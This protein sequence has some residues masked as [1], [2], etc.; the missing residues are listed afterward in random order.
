MGSARGG[1]VVP[2]AR[3][4]EPQCSDT[5]HALASTQLPHS[6]PRATANHLVKPRSKG[7]GT[8]PTSRQRD[9]HVAIY[10]GEEAHG[11]NT[12]R[13]ALSQGPL[14]PLLLSRATSGLKARATPMGSRRTVSLTSR[15]CDPP[16]PWKGLS[17]SVLESFRVVLKGCPDMP[18]GLSPAFP[19]A[20]GYVCPTTGGRGQQPAEPRRAGR[21]HFP[22][23]R[24]CRQVYARLR[25]V[26]SSQ[27]YLTWPHL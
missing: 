5:C 26:P 3:E 19:P 24:C 8:D 10:W 13:A 21:R 15:C 12:A 1:N 27:T 18:R 9:T 23:L 17:S 4:R 11:L 2:E 22:H 7:G 20:L 6:V 25:T 16:P 14:G